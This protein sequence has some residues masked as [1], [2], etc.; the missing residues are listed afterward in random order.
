M[1]K[2]FVIGFIGAAAALMVAA[3]V[4][5]AVQSLDHPALV[6]GGSSYRSKQ[7]FN[8]YLKSKGLSYATWLGR[9]PG[10]APW[11]PGRRAV[12]SD[13]SGE[14][15]DWKRDM[16]LAANAAL[17][18]TLA[19]LL[20]ARTRTQEDKTR[21]VSRDPRDGA[22]PSSPVPAIRRTVAQGLNY[23]ELG[24]GELS[25][26]AIDRI[27]ER[28]ETR[29]ELPLLGVAAVVAAVLGALLALLLN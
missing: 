11:E 29:Q 23:V 28:P 14:P 12:K 10:V 5:F 2:S 15:W 9:N 26:A 18:A 20:L 22:P 1:V 3:A 25:H 27:R 24:A 7:E 16:L 6:W 8:L 19:A 21:T 13:P 4:W 17:L